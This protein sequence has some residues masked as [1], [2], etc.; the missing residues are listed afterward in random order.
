MPDPTKLLATIRKATALTGSTPGRDGNVVE[1]RDAT[2]V[3]VAG[4]LHGDLRSFKGVLDRAELARTPGR[5]LVLQ[6]LVHDIP[7]DPEMGKPDLSHRLVDVVCALKCQYPDRVHVILGNHELSELT[8]RP[9]AKKGIPLNEGFFAGLKLTYG[10]GAEAIYAAYMDHFAALPLAVRTPNRIF[11]VHTLPEAR[12]LEDFDLAVLKA[13]GWTDEQSRRGGP[14]YAMTWGRD[15]SLETAERFAA[16]VDAD[17][18]ICGH[19]PCDQGFLPAN[20]RLLI[21]DGTAPHPASCLFRADRPVTYE[22]L[23]QGVRLVF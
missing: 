15:N 3:I 2:D 1:L 20:P 10:D 22:D 16:M 11:L 19:Q 13:K 8:R 17:F 23:V 4:D 9:I 12:D 6:E 7:A 21:I 14:V 18:F 5:H